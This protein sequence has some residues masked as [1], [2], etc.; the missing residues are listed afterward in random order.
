MPSKDRVSSIY[1]DWSKG[2]GKTTTA[3]V[4]AKALNC[5]KT[6]EGNPCNACQ[7][8]KERTMEETL[9]Y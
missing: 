2:V 1:F 9:M 3:R 8:C 6:K 4:I 7:V 5:S